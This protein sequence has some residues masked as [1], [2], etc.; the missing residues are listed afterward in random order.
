MVIVRK[1]MTIRYNGEEF[2]VRR[3]ICLEKTG[4]KKGKDMHMEGRYV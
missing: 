4:E 1:E 2:N 3:R